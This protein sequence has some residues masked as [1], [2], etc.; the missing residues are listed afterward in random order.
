M[1]LAIW[2][3]CWIQG[4]LA[5]LMGLQSMKSQAVILGNTITI[6]EESHTEQK[7]LLICPIF[8]FH[9]NEIVLKISIIWCAPQIFVVLNKAS[10]LVCLSDTTKFLLASVE[11]LDNCDYL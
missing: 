8:F 1:E 3:T 6:S 10:R 11:L 5:S 2:I 9:L 7:Y 4:V